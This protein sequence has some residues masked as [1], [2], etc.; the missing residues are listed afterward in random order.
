M[1]VASSLFQDIEEGAPVTLA[2][3][4][5]HTGTVLGKKLYISVLVLEWFW[6]YSLECADLVL[7]TDGVLFAFAL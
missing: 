7:A 3:K 2:G 5:F 6:M 1:T 4:E